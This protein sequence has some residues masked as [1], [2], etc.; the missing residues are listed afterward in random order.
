MDDF[1]NGP[2]LI[3]LF[4][5]LDEIRVLNTSCGIKHHL[6]AVLVC[7]FGYCLD[8]GHGNRLSACQVNGHRKADI[9]NLI[10]AHFVNQGLEL[11]Q[12]NIALEIKDCIGVVGLVDND[13]AE[14]CAVAFLMET[15]GCEIHVAGYII[16]WLNGKCG[17]YIL[18]A[19]SLM[20][21]YHILESEQLL[22]RCL[23]VVEVLGTA[24]GFIA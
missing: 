18:C 9:W 7:Q 4:P 13:V 6:D 5:C 17:K 24:V 16:A 19:A 14:G 3:T 11:I 1:L 22:Y 10:S 20:G 23:K 12:V 15:C 2:V 21:G 8:V